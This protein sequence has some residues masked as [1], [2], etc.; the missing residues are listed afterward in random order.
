MKKILLIIIFLL[1]P[2][3]A[4][5][6]QKPTDVPPFVQQDIE[7]TDDRSDV[8]GVGS[9][10]D[11]SS[12]P[13]YAENEGPEPND[14]GLTRQQLIDGG[15]F[16]SL[17]GPPITD[18][19]DKFRTTCAFGKAFDFDPILSFDEAGFEHKHWL[20]GNTD[21]QPDST[22]AQLRES[23]AGSSCGGNLINNTALLGAG[24]CR[25]GCPWRRQ[26]LWAS[27]PSISPSIIRSRPQSTKRRK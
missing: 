27:N 15:Y 23:N 21:L 10:N 26:G 12:A 1:I 3:A 7:F 8:Y 20:F 6:N 5:A 9:A 25:A 2:A 24:A 14:T 19:S 18:T 13:Y 4:L 16:E 17:T 11:P 22:Y